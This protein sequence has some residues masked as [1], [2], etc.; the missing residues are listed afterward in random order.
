MLRGLSC[1]TIV[2]CLRG[3][4]HRVRRKIQLL[5]KLGQRRALLHNRLTV[6]IVTQP[7][8]HVFHR[9]NLGIGHARVE[10]VKRRLIHDQVL[11]FVLL[12]R[13]HQI[14]WRFALSLKKRSP[15]WLTM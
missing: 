15:F 11:R 2:E 7:L 13:L 9:V 12:H 6:I 5:A 8:L 10:V 14:P 1:R 4:F 3:G